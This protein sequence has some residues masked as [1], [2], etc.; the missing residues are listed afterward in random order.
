DIDSITL[1]PTAVD[2]NAQIKVNGQVVASGSAS[3][4]IVL[5]DGINTI[6]VEVTPVVGQSVTYLVH[7]EKEPGIY[8][9][10]LVPSVGTL[11]PAFASET[12]GY[13]QSVDY[14]V[15]T[16]KFTPTAQNPNA[17]IMVNGAVVASG[18]E[19]QAISLDVGDN[20]IAVMILEG[21]VILSMYT[22]DVTR[23][24]SPYLTQILISGYLGPAVQI[25]PTPGNYDYTGNVPANAS[26][27]KIKPTAEDTNAV[28]KVNNEVVAS[29]NLSQAIPISAG[30]NAVTIT[31]TSAT[32]GQ[33]VQYNLTV[34]K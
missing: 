23:S 7:V 31:V 14:S 20:K 3:Q 30:D 27:V 8:L 32:G 18:T 12:F 21:G 28:I 4:E 22:V 19:S 11:T 9:S 26:S 10:N 16:I 29:G 15:E 13:T 1:T 24:S 2:P 5:N 25:D 33:T 17:Q 34:H 6:T